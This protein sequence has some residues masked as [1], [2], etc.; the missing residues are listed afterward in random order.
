MNLLDVYI[1]S[2]ALRG[3]IDELVDV[4]LEQRLRHAVAGAV[5]G[6]EH[7]VRARAAHL[8]FGSFLVDARRQTQARVQRLGRQNQK[9]VVGIR[10]QRGDQTAGLADTQIAQR[11]VIAG[12]GRHAQHPQFHGTLYPVFILVDHHEMARPRAAVH[13]PRPCPQTPEATDDVVAL[14]FVDHIFDPSLSEKL[15]EL[16][17]DRSLRHGAYSE[18]DDH[19]AE[20]DEKGIKYAPGMAQRPNLAVA[21]RGHGG[22][23]H[24]ERVEDRIVFD[25]HE[26]DGSEGQREQDRQPDYGQSSRKMLHW[27]YGKRA[28]RNLLAR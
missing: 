3:E 9:Q 28:R 17:F 7:E 27:S 23:R 20:R 18:K 1:Q 4:R 19:H 5:V 8:L 13:R 12:I 10:T 25:H 24:V 21:H 26:A 15:I 14:Q 16:E 22:E 2:G 11:I 6:S